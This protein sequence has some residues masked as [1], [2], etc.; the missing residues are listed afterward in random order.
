MADQANQQ[1]WET[2][3]D[4]SEYGSSSRSTS[5]ALDIIEADDFSDSASLSESVQAF[6]EEFGRTYHAYRAGS[7]AFPND[8][9][10]QERL[11]SMGECVTLLMKG[12]LYK[13]PLSD[14][15]PPRQ[16]LDIATGVGDWAIQMGDRFPNARIT[17]TDLSPIQPNE[18]PP[19]VHFYVED[20]SEEWMFTH[21][22]DYIH[23]RNTAG[24]WADFESQIAEQ[25]FKNLEP[26]GWFE[27]Q[28]M[29]CTP[30]CDDETHGLAGPVA[31]WCNDLVTASDKLQR[32]AIL[33]AKLKE[34]YERVGFVDVHQRILKMPIN[35]W[36]KDQRLKKL[37]AM[38]AQNLIDG[39]AA[40]SYQLFSKAFERSQA[41]I[42]VSLV[43]VRRDLLNPRIHAYMPVY[44]VWGRK[45]ES[46]EAEQVRSDM[47]GLGV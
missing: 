31:T 29:D 22:F 13:A 26:G 16:I 37:G 15:N 18:V 3:P 2:R 21:K 45:P 12:K 42:E 46:K 7:Y 1:Q 27:S 10:E 47:E 28:E 43:D 9:Q 40:F 17:G 36:P 34:I 20:S 4:A 38:W 19:N 5:V 30:L 44:V 8:A 24:S 32:P 39:L 14:A 41:Q 33:G 6:P 23:T 35:D 11:S 25:A